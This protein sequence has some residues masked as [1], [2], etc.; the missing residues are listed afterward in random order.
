MQRLIRRPSSW[1]TPNVPA[2]HGSICTWSK[3][4]MPRRRSAACH[5]GCS[6][7]ATMAVIDSPKSSAG[8]MP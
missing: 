8:R 3:S 2:G 5:S 7:T 6:F 4:S 1:A